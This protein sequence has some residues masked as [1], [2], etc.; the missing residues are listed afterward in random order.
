MNANVNPPISRQSIRRQRGPLTSLVADR[1]KQL[2]HR[3]VAEFAAYAGISESG[4]YSVLNG[5]IEE[6]VPIIPKWQT[7]VA[8]AR[9]LERPT[10]ELLYILDPSAP[11]AD[12]QFDVT[13]VPVYM[14]GCVGAGPEQLHEL[15]DKIYVEAEFAQGRDLVAF[16]VCGDSMAGGRR[17][18][19]DSDVVIVD[20]N[21]GAEVNM[22]VVA[23]LKNDGYVCKRFRPGGILDSANPE[24]VDPELSLI[25]PD[26][27]AQLVGRVVRV[28]SNV[29]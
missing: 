7:M 2:G 11:G 20:R 1:M 15:E 4:M 16:K 9:A 26:Q 10:H 22:P 8:L 19:Y 17:P 14:A 13:T 21:V 12:L 28:Q 24:Y 27:V 23:R 3:N 29:A 6:G 18:I 5:R 25:S